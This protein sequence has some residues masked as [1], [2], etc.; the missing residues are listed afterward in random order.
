M[1]RPI[2]SVEMVS[3]GILVRFSD[4]LLTYYPHGFL[5]DHSGT[6]SNQIFL[7]AHTGPLPFA[8]PGNR[9]PFQQIN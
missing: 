4:G 8:T 9:D 5:R 7:E 2:Q 3:D 6:G 1:E